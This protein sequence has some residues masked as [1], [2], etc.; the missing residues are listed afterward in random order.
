MIIYNI[1]FALADDIDAEEWL[2]FIKS[3]YLNSAVETGFFS[4][5]EV[6]GLKRAPHGDAGTTFACQLKTDAIE[7]IDQFEKEK[8]NIFDALIKAK[9]GERCLSFITV[10]EKR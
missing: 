1:T 10:L 2:S 8:K 3:G 7:K 5:Y 4:E 6:F 9:Y